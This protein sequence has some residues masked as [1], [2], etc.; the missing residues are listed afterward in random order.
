LI[1]TL[2]FFL[3]HL[4]IN[5]SALS[6]QNE[7]IEKLL[8]NLVL[9]ILGLNLKI[10]KDGKNLTDRDTRVWLEQVKQTWDVFLHIQLHFEWLESSFLELPDV[11]QLSVGD[12]LEFLDLGQEVIDV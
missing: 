6:K 9:Q 5:E 10:A 3:A 11:I 2:H 12:L 4:V 1:L 7:G 8:L